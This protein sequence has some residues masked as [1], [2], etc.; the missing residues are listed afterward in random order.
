MSEKETKKQMRHEER[1]EAFYL[2]FE[3]IFRK[4]DI[5]TIIEDARAARDADIGKYTR[6]IAAG[7]SEKAEELD[8]YIESNLRSWKM[9]RISKV[10]LAIMRIA[11]YEML[12]VEDVPVSVSINEAIELAKEFATAADGSFVNGVLGSVAKQIKSSGDR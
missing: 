11:V 10:A 2:L 6:L 5:N 9:N 1:K 7:V 3:Q 12:Y 4:D 8:R